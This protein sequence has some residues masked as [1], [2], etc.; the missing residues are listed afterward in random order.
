M[1]NW[2]N[3]NLPYIKTVDFKKCPSLLSKRHNLVYISQC[4]S[5]GATEDLA[6]N[7][8]SGK[9]LSLKMH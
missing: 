2:P 5:D 8:D 7:D 9:N 6:A 4:F 3:S 1:G